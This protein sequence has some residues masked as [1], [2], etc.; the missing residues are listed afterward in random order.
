M[1]ILALL[2]PIQNS[3]SKTTIRQLSCVIPAMIAMTGRVTMLGLSRWTEKGGSYR[4]IQRFFY[5]AIPWAQ[6][7]WTFFCEHLL[8]QQDTYLLAGDESVITKA[9]EKTHGLDYFFSGLLKKA[10]PGLS[11]FTLALI[12]IKQ[13][14]SYPVCMEQTVRTAEE[15]AASQVK[16]QVMKAKPEG[17]KRNPGRPKG[18]RNRN[19]A[20]VTLNPELQRIQK[21]LQAFQNTV[22]GTI[23]LTYLVLDG[24]FGNHPAWHMVRQCQL[25]LISKL[26]SDAALF[27]S[28]TGPS[29]KRGPRPRLGERV[30]IR[31]IPAV[32]LK[33]SKV[34]DGIQSCTYQ[35]QL[36]HRE[37]PD[38]LNVVILLKTNLETKA[39][40]HVILFSSDLELS[41]DQLIDFYSLRFQIE[42]NFR[43]A[44]QF[45]GLEDFMN[46]TQT[47]VTNSANL[48]LFMI[49]ISQVLMYEYRQDDPNFSILDLKAYYRGYRYVTETIKLLPQ[50]PDGNLV[51]Q[52]FHKA[53]ALGRIHPAKI[54]VSSG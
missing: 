22:Q 17:P 23:H 6:V 7:F 14:R 32:Y 29:P 35:M 33:E 41:Y 11:F 51:A 21:M 9:G 1:D 42:F 53:T 20:E 31:K 26:R 38:L 45:W 50:I 2:Q 19:K 43:D 12:S 44:K 3:V 52:L 16:K 18:S 8:D 36:L 39:W 27:F 15:K 54:P 4:T 40:A 30:D 47:A 10:V 37:F 25:H 48:S 28:Y 49:D 46:V 5:T 13:R 34:E 24:H